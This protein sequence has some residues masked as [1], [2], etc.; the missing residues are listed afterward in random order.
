[1]TAGDWVAALGLALPLIANAAFNGANYLESKKHYALAALI[2]MGG[3][4]AA[5]AA[6]ALKDIP[7]GADPVRYEK[8]LISSAA[9]TIMNEMDKKAAL[10]SA[11]TPQ[12]Q[13]IVQGEMDKLIVAPVAIVPTTVTTPL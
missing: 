13:T 5:S 12:V 8:A 1:M 10:V 4:Q 2:G 11:D 7:P 9:S 3:R 6:R